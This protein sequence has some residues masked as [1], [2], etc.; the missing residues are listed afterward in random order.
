[1][2]P[3]KT[4]RGMYE[5]RKKVH[6]D[7]G[8]STVGGSSINRKALIEGWYT[9]VRCRMRFVREPL[10]FHHLRTVSDYGK[11]WC[12]D[13]NHGLPETTLDTF[14]NCY[15]S[16]QEQLSSTR[17]RCA[18]LTIGRALTRWLDNVSSCSILFTSL[19]GRV[20][21]LVKYGEATYAG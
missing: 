5:H 18:R 19:L 2:K 17:V 21:L 15:R 4:L 9:C 1:M 12:E 20:Y 13:D 8:E 6:F 10:I 3:L 7:A 11:L 14:L 16:A